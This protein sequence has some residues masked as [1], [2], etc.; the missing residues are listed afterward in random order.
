MRTLA[1]VLFVALLSSCA[2]SGGGARSDAKEAV[3]A[4]TA[5]WAA[6]FNS[7]IPARITSLYAPDA[8]FWGTTA[9]TISPTPAAI[10]EYFKDVPQRPDARVSLGEQHIRVYGDTAVNTGYYTFSGPGRDGKAAARP[11]RFTFVYAYRD[12]KWWIVDHHSSFLPVP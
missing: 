12:G 4:A 10:A 5:E 3:S 6:A 1:T 8:V 2:G 9:K 11:A 7:R